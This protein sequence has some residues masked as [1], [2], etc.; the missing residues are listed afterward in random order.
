MVVKPE[1]GFFKIAWEFFFREF[2]LDFPEDYGTVG[3]SEAQSY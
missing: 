2:F 1:T 3:A